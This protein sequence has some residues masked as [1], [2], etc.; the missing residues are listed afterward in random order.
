MT[1]GRIFKIILLFYYMMHCGGCFFTLVNETIMMPSYTSAAFISLQGLLGENPCGDDGTEFE[2][3]HTE[4]WYLMTLMLAGAMMNAV[5]FGQIALLIQNLNRTSNRYRH[6]LDDVSESM[7]HLRLPGELRTR[8]RNFFDFK[9]HTTKCLDHNEFQG[10][11][12][13]PLAREI[14]L[15]TNKR[16]VTKVPLFDGVDPDFL[17]ALV[18]KLKPR[19]YLPGDYIILENET[20]REMYFIK[21]GRAEVLVG[22]DRTCV[23]AFTAG[24]FFGEIAVMLPVRRTA[25]VC[26][27]D[28]CELMILFKG[29]LDEVMNEYPVSAEVVKRKIEVKVRKYMQQNKKVV[30]KAPGKSHTPILDI[31][32]INRQIKQKTAT[33]AR[34]ARDR[35][36]GKLKRLKTKKSMRLSKKKSMRRKSSKNVL[37]HDDDEDSLEHVHSFSEA[38][39]DGQSFMVS[40]K[41]LGELLTK[42]LDE[43]DVESSKKSLAAARRSLA[44]KGLIK[45]VKPPKPKTPKPKPKAPKA[46]R[47][48]KSGKK[49][50]NVIRAPSSTPKKRRSQKKV[51]PK[52]DDADGDGTAS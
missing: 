11:L 29:D 34:Q 39:A 14:A 50:G 18:C 32:K 23:H 21:S 31:D 13:M 52:R 47:P 19:Q 3:T 20:G 46:P 42:I 36:K 7:A 27:D 6:M 37:H 33:L 15:W 1:G 26:A 12:S 2:C 10:R 40:R 44:K 28:Y 38:D 5:F 45:G 30:D 49:G 4:K 35:V 43:R 17:T 51:H 48:K 24:E 8:I 9:W 41:E 16:L 25:T 22:G